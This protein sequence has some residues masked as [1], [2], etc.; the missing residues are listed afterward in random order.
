MKRRVFTLIELLV[1]IAIIAI[2]AAML[3]P[4]LNK[5]RDRARRTQC[6][7]NLKQIGTLSVFY[8]DSYKM[9]VLIYRQADNSYWPD[10]MV[11]GKQNLY[12]YKGIMR[13]PSAQ[14]GKWTA[15]D[16]WNNA[17]NIYGIW[18]TPREGRWGGFKEVVDGKTTV[19]HNFKR[20]ACPSR[21]PLIADSLN[22]AGKQA[23]S[24]TQYMSG[25]MVNI[26]HDGFAN[27][28]WGDAHVAATSPHEYAKAV[29]DTME[30]STAEVA[31]FYGNGG[32][33]RY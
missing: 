9:Y 23:N 16:Y 10:L 2:L 27:I 5:A 6:T 28:L 14:P 3:L 1:V 19:G 21:Y 33:I 13:C 31:C 22:T 20:I 25:N 17:F 18:G 12:R 30:I 26:R 4:A 8:Q 24:V 7:N 32:G 15:D 29:R 11:G